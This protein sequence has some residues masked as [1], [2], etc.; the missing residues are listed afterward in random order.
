MKVERQPGADV[1]NEVEIIRQLN[2]PS[3]PR[4]FDFSLKAPRFIVTAEMPGE[5]L[6]AILENDESQSSRSYLF[7][8]GAAVAAFHRLQIDCRPV[9]DRPFFHLPDKRYFE[10]NE[11]EFLFDY[12]LNNRPA[13]VNQCFVH[14]DC[15]YANILWKHGHISAILDYELAGKGNKEFDLAWAC[16]LRPGQKFLNSI[17]EI[18]SFLNGYSSKGVFDYQSFAYHYAL[19]GSHFYRI[20]N[21]EKGYREMLVDLIS[22]VTKSRPRRGA[23]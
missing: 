4:I 11:I 8:F 15:H 7:E 10:K 22:K 2:F 14:G 1:A 19:I 23:G 9:K 18:D 17:E 3:V 20:G 21:C 13:K 5:R 12:L 6:S 16:L